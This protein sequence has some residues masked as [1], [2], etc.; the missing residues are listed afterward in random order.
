MG[1]PSAWRRPAHRRVVHR[2]RD[3]AFGPGRDGAVAHESVGPLLCRPCYRQ[4][5][6]LSADRRRQSFG[7]SVVFRD[8]LLPS[9]WPGSSRPSTQVATV[10]AILVMPG[11]SPGMTAVEINRATRTKTMNF[12]VAI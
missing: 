3:V 11:S 1:R 8:H 2:A 10:W 6:A 5:H 4:Q 9:S 12:T 7:L